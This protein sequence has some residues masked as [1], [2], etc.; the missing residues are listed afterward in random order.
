MAVADHEGGVGIR[1]APPGPGHAVR[2]D[3][4]RVRPD[5]RRRGV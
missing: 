5:R 3:E 1:P 4:G 2:R